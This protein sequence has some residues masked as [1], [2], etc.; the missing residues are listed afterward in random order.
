M[1][2][3]LEPRS[4]PV[5]VGERQVLRAALHFVSRGGS[6]SEALDASVRFAG[7]DNYC[8][9]LVGGWVGAPY[10]GRDDYLPGGQGKGLRISLS[11]RVWPSF[12]PSLCRRAFTP[13]PPARP[14]P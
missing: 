13:G 10:M 1:V 5:V 14:V 7:P 12:Q 8:P 3:F 9:V 6:F 2:V 4:H 11:E